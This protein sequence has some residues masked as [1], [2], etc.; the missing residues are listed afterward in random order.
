MFT[1][2]F[3][4]LLKNPL[5]RRFYLNVLF[6]TSRYRN[7]ILSSLVALHLATE[8]RTKVRPQ[9]L[10]IF[11]SGISKFCLFLWFIVLLRFRLGC[12]A[13]EGGRG[14]ERQGET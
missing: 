3:T 11:L 5:H 4:S 13:S 14:L 8:G 12:S 9:R 6:L 1:G 10:N 2:V 7:G